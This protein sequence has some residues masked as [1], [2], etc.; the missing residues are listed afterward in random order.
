MSLLT[1]SSNLLRATKRMVPTNGLRA[2][3][4]LSKQ[5]A[6]DYKKMD[7]SA[8][9]NKKGRPVSPHL[10]IYAFPIAALSSIT[11]R[12]TGMTLS[13]GAAGVA[14]AELIGGGGT[15]M[16]I[17][18]T[19][20][21]QGIIIASGAKFAVAFPMVYHYFG[22]VRHLAWDHFPKLLTNVGVEKSSYFL[23]AS[24]LLVSSGFMLA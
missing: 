9:M 23:Y 17:M 7:Y 2:M 12:V 6:E 10:Q 15:T 14:A 19:I 8:R 3:T 5:S 11:I 4:V 13:F 22:A 21:S 18:Q 16:Y 24:S 1:L 20:G